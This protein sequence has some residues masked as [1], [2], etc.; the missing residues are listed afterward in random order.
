[1]EAATTAGD[2]GGVNDDDDEDD[3]EAEDE[4]DE[5]DADDDKV[6]EEN[7]EAVEVKRLGTKA[8][9]VGVSAGARDK[10]WHELDKRSIGDG[11]RIEDAN[12]GGREASSSNM[13]RSCVIMVRAGLIQ[14]AVWLGCCEE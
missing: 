5:D 2:E 13:R 4:D 14:R 11:T 8:L 6:E 3:D 7:I 1:M 10:P 12:N 9:G